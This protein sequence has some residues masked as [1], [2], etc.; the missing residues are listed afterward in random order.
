M[1]LVEL[2]SIKK[3]W[4]KLMRTSLNKEQGYRP[5]FK[6]T[7]KKFQKGMAIANYAD[8]DDE[9]E[10]YDDADAAD[11]DDEHQDGAHDGDDDYYDENHGDYNYDDYNYEDYDDDNDYSDDEASDD[12]DQVAYVDPMGHFI[13]NQEVC[14]QIDESFAEEDVDYNQKVIDYRTARNALAHARIV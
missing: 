5:R 14:D 12:P 8:G 3:S 11:E 1:Y 2:L 13:C 6:Q 9:E 4:P 7:S 10:E